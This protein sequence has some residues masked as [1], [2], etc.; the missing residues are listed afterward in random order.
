MAEQEKEGK[1]VV[2]AGG[3]EKEKIVHVGA[4][5]DEE[6]QIA[7]VGA[8]GDEEKGIVPI[9]AGNEEQ[10]LIRNCGQVRPPPGFRFRPE[11]DE[12]VRYYLIPKLQ[13]RDHVLN[14]AII[15]D[16][17]YQCHPNKLTRTS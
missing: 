4:G 11:Y 12:L 15:E 17:V 2:G 7:L 10:N 14:K 6:K 5:G 9:G 3:D 16:D 8:G 1:A 13:G